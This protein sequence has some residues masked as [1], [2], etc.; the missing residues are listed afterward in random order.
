MQAPARLGRFEDLS[1]IDEGGQATVFR[2]RDSQTGETVAVK[3]L[4][5]GP[6]FSQVHLERFRFEAE[7]VAGINHPN[8]VRLI[9]GDLHGIPKFLAFE[10]IEGSLKGMLER[11]ARPGVEK[12]AWIAYQVAQGL[13]AAHATGVIHRDV[14]PSNILLD[15][16]D[17]ARLIDF[18]I[19]RGVTAQTLT[20]TGAMVG[21]A[22]YMS[23]EQA[24]PSLLA[25]RSDLGPQSGI[26]SLGVVLYEMAVGHVP[27]TSES[28]LAIARMHVEEDTPDVLT[29]NPEVPGWLAGIIE[30]CLQKN[31]DDRFQ[32]ATE[33]ADALASHVPDVVDRHAE[34]FRREVDDRTKTQSFDGSGISLG[35]SS[36]RGRSKWWWA[37]AAMVVLSIAASVIASVFPWDEVGEAGLPVIDLGVADDPA[38][39]DVAPDEPVAGDGPSGDVVGLPAPPATLP[40]VDTEPT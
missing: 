9:G 2:A 27:Y 13:E 8:V 16:D 14:K 23:P 17:T 35:G 38:G 33:L 29:A 39:G 31:P 1:R 3:V 5:D 24:E 34:L 10:Y 28:P 15:G 18:G 20:R 30:R 22:L 37:V 4:H 25:T 7:T 40:Q 26:Y 21:T 32:T 12:L 6:A 11:D 36:T 19:A